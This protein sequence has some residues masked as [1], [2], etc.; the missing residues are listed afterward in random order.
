MS[1]IVD[2]EATSLSWPGPILSL[3]LIIKY[4]LPSAD[5]RRVVSVTSKRYVHEVLANPL[6]NLDQEK[7]T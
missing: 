4:F 7:C 6:V 2:L 5:S 1:L 3:S